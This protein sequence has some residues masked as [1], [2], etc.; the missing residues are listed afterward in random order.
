M[1]KRILDE[2]I[3]TIPDAK[4]SAS[5]LL[6]GSEVDKIVQSYEDIERGRLWV[7][8]RLPKEGRAFACHRAAIL[9]DFESSQ[10]KLRVDALKGMD[11]SQQFK[12]MIGDQYGYQDS[13]IVDNA[14]CYFG[15]IVSNNYIVGIQRAYRGLAGRI[16]S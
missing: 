13:G 10:V 15:E 16:R 4:E 5:R 3:Q 9:R 14:V 11:P 8:F 12:W 7:L 1:G 6:F 2:L